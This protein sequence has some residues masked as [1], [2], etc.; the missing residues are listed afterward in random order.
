MQLFQTLPRKVLTAEAVTAQSPLHQLTLPGSALV[1]LLAGLICGWLGSEWSLSS[2]QLQNSR[3]DQG[4]C[5]IGD[6]A[7]SCCVFPVLVLW[8]GEG[9]GNMV[10]MGSVKASTSEPAR[11]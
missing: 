9:L 7:T 5:R 1:C 2:I 11:V 10:H 6:F 3:R 4:I 8:P